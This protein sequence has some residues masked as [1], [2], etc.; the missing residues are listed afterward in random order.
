MKTVKIIL[1]FLVRITSLFFRARHPNKPCKPVVD[2]ARHPVCLPPQHGGS[3]SCCGRD[4]IAVSNTPSPTPVNMLGWALI[5]S[6]AG[7]YVLKMF[8]FTGL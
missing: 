2:D 1:D 8:V 6:A 3:P 5:M 7:G 4:T